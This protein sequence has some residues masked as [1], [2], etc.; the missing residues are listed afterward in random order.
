MWG[1]QVLLHSVGGTTLPLEMIFP[2]HRSRL[3]GGGKI[4]SSTRS[5][6]LIQTIHP[7]CNQQLNMSVNK[8]LRRLH[9]MAPTPIDRMSASGAGTFG[10]P[11]EIW[12][13]I[14]NDA[15]ILSGHIL[16]GEFIDPSPYTKL[17][18]CEHTHYSYSPYKPPL[19]EMRRSFSLVCK[20]WYFIANP[21]LWSHV[22]LNLDRELEKMQGLYR[23][24]SQY[25]SL[26]SHVT[27]I[28][29]YTV[30]QG[31]SSPPWRTTPTL[32]DNQCKLIQKILSRL[33]GLKMV[34]CP[35]HVMQSVKWAIQPEVVVI[36]RNSGR[37]NDYGCF[38]G[39]HFWNYSRTLVL[40]AYGR[41]YRVVYE[42]GWGPDWDDDS[43]PD[44]ADDSGYIIFKG[45]VN[46]PNLVNLRIQVTSGSPIK[47]LAENWNCP[48]LRSLSITNGKQL[49][50]AQFIRKV[51]S[52][53]E[54]LELL[55]YDHIDS[56]PSPSTIDL[57]ALNTLCL[58]MPLNARDGPVQWWLSCLNAPRLDRLII[59]LERSLDKYHDNLMLFAKISAVLHRYHTVQ[60]LAIVLPRP[61]WIFDTSG[62]EGFYYSTTGNTKCSLLSKQ[63]VETWCYHG[64]QVEM[65]HSETGR[66]QKYTTNSFGEL[67]ALNA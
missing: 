9:L 29:L 30:K 49:W 38:Y 39:Y 45:P 13:K 22:L 63:E 62:T 40:P 2:W 19:F 8:I 47:F 61:D 66:E 41:I 42:S 25:R 46:F 34:T 36:I 60:Q 27:C 18:E 64:I 48:H 37:Y 17:L 26:A 23:T 21:I 10:V 54:R 33:V 56:I 43:E 65:I 12:H 31:D 35:H 44:D 15:M 32:A 28:T 6:H 53:L 4:K 14:F 57:P 5:P 1:L 67:Q 11:V 52:T 55:I 50:W 58:W 3:R 59:H 16:E 24:L 20:S 51:S 7:V